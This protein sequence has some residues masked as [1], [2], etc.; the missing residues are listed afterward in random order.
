M[1]YSPFKQQQDFFL[2]KARIRCLF[3]A[4]RAGKSEIMHLDTITKLEQRPNYDVK[5]NDPYMTALIAPT[6]QMLKKL[7]WPKFFSFA[8]PFINP[9]RD[10]NKTENRLQWRNGSVVYGISAEKIKRMEGLKLNHVAIDEAFQ[11][12]EHVLYESLARVSDSKGT[13]VIGGSLGTEINNPKS[14]W[15][16]QMFKQ[17]EFEDSE[18]FEWTT[19]DNPHFP[20]DELERL[21]NT[22]DPRT[23]KQLFT[24]DWNTPPTNIVYD[25]LSEDNFIQYVYRDNLPTYCCIDWGWNHEMACLFFQYHPPADTVYLFDEIVSSKMTLD[26]L[27]KKIKAKGYRIDEWYC[28]TAGNQTREQSGISNIKWFR[29]KGI[30]FKFRQTAISYGIPIVRSYIKSTSGEIRFYIDDKKCPKSTDQ[31]LN[32]HYAT[33]AGVLQEKPEDKEDDCADAIRYLFV[34]R[35]DKFKGKTELKEVD[36]WQ[37]LKF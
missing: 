23:Y 14:H 28:D 5:S 18:V 3:A 11:M 4:K 2:S 27:Y 1:I 13:I 36:K 26:S 33:K 35:L 32:Y 7:I 8:A 20:Q 9:D 37:Y 6:E 12:T 17:K 29:D 19:S 16:Y 30:N 34:N 22:L 31:M 15:L 10:F 21:K 25:N 24:I